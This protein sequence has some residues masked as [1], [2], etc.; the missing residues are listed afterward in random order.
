VGA[1]A[2]LILFCAA[3]AML[4]DAAA[5]SAADA[6][7]VA[8]LLEQKSQWP[9]FASSGLPMK[10]EGRYLIFSSNLLRFMKCEDLNFVWHE[11]EQPFPV[12]LPSLHTRTIE[13]YGRFA[14]QAEKPVFRVER[15]REIPAD[16]E[17]LRVRRLALIDAPA[18]DWY[19]LG[20]WALRRGAFYGDIELPTEARQ[21]FAEGIRRERKT[22]P[23]DAL[24]AQIALSQKFQKYGLPDQDRCAFVH[25]AF[26]LRWLSIKGAHPGTRDLEELTDRLSDN[27]RGCRT[28]LDQRAAGLSERYW[29]NPVGFYHDSPGATRLRLN[30]I[31]YSDIRFAFLQAWARQKNVDGLQLADRIDHEVPEFHAEAEKSRDQTLNERLAAAATLSRRDVLKL[32]ELFTQRGQPAKALQAKSAW[33]L[34]GD[35][36]LRNEGRPDDL[37]QAAHEHQ[38]MLDDNEG[39][40]KLLLEAYEKSPGM[41][42][43]SE[44]LNR[45]GWTRVGG[46]WMTLAQAAALP[47]D[48]SKQAADAGHL[49]GMSRDQVRKALSS[50]PDSV[51]RVITA[52]RLNE[53]WIYN[54]NAGSR[55]A[56]HF[57]GS[58]D[59]RD[60]RVVR[61]VQ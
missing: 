2:A 61:M 24:E 18:A 50:R 57:L 19:A 42:D 15:V 46:K 7:S 10:I 28:P 33:V 35:E 40:V 5:A 17:T 30:R 51:T 26:A 56:I 31:L 12:D 32:A 8:K 43:I 14:L 53:V 25:E 27:L 23:D 36:R 37:I 45:L 22:L 4:A 58:A 29:H 3:A 52:G 34:A 1:R 59:G 49:V 11:D 13:V 20:D 16:A 39:A 41:K 44:Q 21:L 38:S 55:L 9:S 48:P 60:L 54:E 6:I 47:P